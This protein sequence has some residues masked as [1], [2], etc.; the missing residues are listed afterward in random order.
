MGRRADEEGRLS[1]IHHPTVDGN[2]DFAI[3]REVVTRRYWRLKEERQPMPGLVL[4]DGGLGQLHAAADALEA[5]GSPIS[6]WRRSPSA[7]R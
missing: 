3:M 1:Q 4:V 6:R 2:D 7:R 5:S